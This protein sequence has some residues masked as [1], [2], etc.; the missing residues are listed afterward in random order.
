MADFLTNLVTRIREGA[1]FVRPRLPS[2]FEPPEG[3]AGGF[4]EIEITGDTARNG[5]SPPS[6]AQ[7]SKSSEDSRA[8]AD[9]MPGLS[10]RRVHRSE[11]TSSI[12]ETDSAT[13]ET[14]PLGEPKRPGSGG[15]KERAPAVTDA[16]PIVAAARPA[17]LAAHAMRE[18]DSSSAD[19]APPQMQPP[20]ALAH[21]T[22]V[23]S[24]RARDVMRQHS[25]G[26]NRPLSV[27]AIVVPS[28]APRAAIDQP[29]VN[30]PSASRPPKPRERPVRRQTSNAPVSEPTVHVTIGRIDVRAVSV[31]APSARKERDSSPVMSLDEYLRTRTPR[32][33]Q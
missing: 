9:L 5:E 13:G 22:P 10:Q 7:L 6:E 25:T 31:A 17:E 30:T 4:S 18:Q 27:A 15:P 14:A 8:S 3:G 26:L 2:M 16:R 29:L 21:R 32:G 20:A 1:D 28:G 23:E 19:V 33:R 12:G 11:I 24:D